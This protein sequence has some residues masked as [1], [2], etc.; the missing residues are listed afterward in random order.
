MKLNRAIS[1]LE[2]HNKWRRGNVD[3]MDYT[4]K[5]LGEAIDLILTVVKKLNKPQVSMEFCEH[6]Y[7]FRDNSFYQYYE[8]K[9]C[10]HVQ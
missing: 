5:E 3:G 9:K 10:G 6:E 4:V 1:I 8:C 2:T 7:Q